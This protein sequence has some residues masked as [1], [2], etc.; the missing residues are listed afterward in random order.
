M[1]PSLAD[2]NCGKNIT[3]PHPWLLPRQVLYP[4]PDGIPASEFF[5]SGEL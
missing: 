5:L 4:A 3:E 2:G 1:R